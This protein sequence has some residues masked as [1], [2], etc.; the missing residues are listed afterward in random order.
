MLVLELDPRINLFFIILFN[1]LVFVPTKWVYPTRSP[2]LFRL[3]LFITYF[4]CSIGAIGVLLY[5]NEPQWIWPLS[6]VYSIYYIG[7]SLWP[8]RVTT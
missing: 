2:R 1:I 6:L 4:F 5:P 3:T 7:L 8:R